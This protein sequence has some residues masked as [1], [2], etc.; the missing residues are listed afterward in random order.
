M[1]TVTADFKVAT[2]P[3]LRSDAPCSAVSS[4]AVPREPSRSRPGRTYVRRDF[5]SEKQQKDEG[6]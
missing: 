6:A 4:S 3:D 2:A 5:S 1:K